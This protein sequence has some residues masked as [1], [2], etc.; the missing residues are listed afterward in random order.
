[1]KV[2][3]HRRWPQAVTAVV[4]LQEST[5]CR[6]GCSADVLALLTSQSAPQVD[7]NSLP[8]H[9]SDLVLSVPYSL[10]AVMDHHGS[11]LVKA[12][13]LRMCS[14]TDSLRT[15]PFKM[16][17]HYLLILKLVACVPHVQ[18]CC[19]ETS[20]KAPKSNTRVTLLLVDCFRASGRLVDVRITKQTSFHLQGLLAIRLP[21]TVVANLCY[22]CCLLKFS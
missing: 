7:L 13:Y 4:S 9:Q 5:Q 10:A 22:C 21:P 16:Y 6:L 14:T 15:S 17:A 1:M 3:T 11:R 19:Q 20:S 8:P 2:S 18:V 12:H